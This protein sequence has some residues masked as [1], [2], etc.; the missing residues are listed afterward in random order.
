METTSARSVV[1]EPGGSGVVAHVGLHALCSFA[2]RLRLGAVLSSRIPIHAERSPL[3]DRGK[4][5]VQT[6]AM[7]AGGGETCADIEHLRSEQSLFGFVPSDSTLWRCFHEIT[8][9]TRAGLKDAF[10]EVRAA[11]WR[12]S[13][14]TTGSAP[15]VLDV[16]ASLVEIH[17]EG[18]DG[19][20]P[21]YKGGFGFH[22]LLLFAD[23]T[24][25]LLSSM[26]RPGNAGANTVAD[27][28]VVL[29]E[30]VTQLPGEIARGHHLGDDPELVFRPVVIR[31]DSAGCT[32]GFV[33][34]CRARNI[35][36]SVVARSNAQIHSAIFDTLG[37]EECWAP[38]LR[39]NGELREG[40][41][42][43]ELTDLVDLSSW[44]TGTRLIVRR[45]PLHPGAQ[46]S[47]FP[48]LEYRYWG[49]YTDEL[50]DPVELDC[51]MRAHAHVEENISRLKD[52]GLL[53]FPF[54]EIEANRNWLMVVAM[55][56]DLV[57]WFQLLCL[58][59]AL[60]VARPKAL[61]WSLF[62]APGRIVRS[63]RREIVR[64]LDGWP[65]AEALLA[66][67]RRIALIT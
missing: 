36:F 48:S 15:V 38:A 60:A 40:A 9:V 27:H 58:D 49:H 34:G 46:Q 51:F 21:N 28:L 30:A 45:E 32:E 52:S 18:K 17:N 25:E 10:G 29:E 12:R 4:V 64:I 26:L 31:S 20:G 23:A 2:D 65:S 43:T 57:R 13:D 41:A 67:H 62:H 66:A 63:A 24:G 1:V 6:M 54:S 39:Q 35:G 42:V 47:L 8:P 37:F 33:N 50:G 3:H 14:A 59:G 16:D 44:P 5:L 22:P 61:R 53:R 56:A 11:V 19:T 55:A 7:L